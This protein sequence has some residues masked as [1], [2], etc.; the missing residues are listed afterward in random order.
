MA[1]NNYSLQFLPWF[2]GNL[3]K[4]VQVLPVLA[5]PSVCEGMAGSEPERE[6]EGRLNTAVSASF[7]LRTLS[8]APAFFFYF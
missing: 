1:A 7:F 8:A 6:R 5:L 3:E 2:E 4:E